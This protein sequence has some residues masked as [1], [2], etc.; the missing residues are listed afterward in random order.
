MSENGLV[1]EKVLRREWNDARVSAEV[2]SDGRPFKVVAPAA[3]RTRGPRVERR[4]HGTS[5]REV[6]AD[7]SSRRP[8][9]REVG[10][11]SDRYDGVEPCIARYI[12]TATLNLILSGTRSRCGRM[13]TSF[14]GLNERA[15]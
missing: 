6:S 8:D 9:K 11:N 10:T 3:G 2:M 14:T 5:K 13:G 12:R 7:P 15:G 1:N 4:D